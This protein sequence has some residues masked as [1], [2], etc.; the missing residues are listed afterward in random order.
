MGPNWFFLRSPTALR[1]YMLF[2]GHTL[3]NSGVRYC[4]D[5]NPLCSQCTAASGTFYHLI[6]TCPIYRPFVYKSYNFYMTG[7]GSLLQLDPKPC[8]LGLLLDPDMDKFLT[9][10]LHMTLFQCQKMY[11][12]FLDAGSPSYSPSLV[13]RC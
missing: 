10:F 2:I 7:W 9:T 6:W 4:P 5:S 3:L 1:N 8:L 12:T 11:C 13:D